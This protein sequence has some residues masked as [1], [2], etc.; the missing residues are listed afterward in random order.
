MAAWFA[1]YNRTQ[2]GPLPATYQW[3]GRDADTVAELNPKTLTSG[4]RTQRSPPR[5][6][7]D[8][9]PLPQHAARTETAATPSVLLTLGHS[10]NPEVIGC[11]FHAVAG[12]ILRRLPCP[13][14]G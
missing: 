5:C 6:R 9:L 8:D 10:L 3:R 1:W 4:P 13:V 14:C 12:W 7:T 11:S 2:A